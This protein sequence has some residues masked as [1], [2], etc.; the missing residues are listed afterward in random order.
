LYTNSH[1]LLI[2]ETFCGFYTLTVDWHYLYFH[3]YFISTFLVV[4]YWYTTLP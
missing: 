3:S 1:D 4:A 2:F